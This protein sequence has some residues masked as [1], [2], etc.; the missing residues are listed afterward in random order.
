MEM[1]MEKLTENITELWNN[2][3]K[4]LNGE[5]SIYY[6][7]INYLQL[8][9]EIHIDIIHIIFQYINFEE[10]F[11][12][13]LVKII[14]DIYHT[15]NEN[16]TNYYKIKL[17]VKISTLHYK[18]FPIFN[19]YKNKNNYYDYYDK[20]FNNY[21]NVVRDN[22][23]GSRRLIES[24][25]LDNIYVKIYNY[26]VSIKYIENTENFIIKSQVNPEEYIKKN[27][28]EILLVN[29]IIKYK[30]LKM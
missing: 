19:R 4:L 14:Y 1:E 28:N 21:V 3:M 16:I 7:I 25:Y 27:F 9:R 2:K 5:D 29:D 6:I 23:F 30:I 24:N 13:G 8:N 12:N 22:T 11:Y 20:G 18:N 15:D 17:L 10:L 26:L